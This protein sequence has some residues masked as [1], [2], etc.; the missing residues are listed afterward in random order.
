MAKFNPPRRQA[1]LGLSRALFSLANDV[2][3]SAIKTNSIKRNEDVFVSFPKR[4]F[5]D[6]GLGLDKR[7][8]LIMTVLT[9]IGKEGRRTL[10]EQ[11]WR[12]QVFPLEIITHGDDYW[13]VI[14]DFPITVPRNVGENYV[15][16]LVVHCNTKK[17]TMAYDVAT[18]KSRYR[19]VLARDH[20][21]ASNLTL[22]QLFDG[23]E[24][25]VRCG[26]HWLHY[27]PLKA[28]LGKL[29]Y[30][31]VSVLASLDIGSIRGLLERL[32]TKHSQYYVREGTEMIRYRKSFDDAPEWEMVHLTKSSVR[33][34]IAFEEYL[35]IR[36]VEWSQRQARRYRTY[37]EWEEYLAAKKGNLPHKIPS[38]EIP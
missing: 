24:T 15:R 5:Y 33:Y 29:G 8:K 6:G 38:R 32:S 4:V 1:T 26:S 20:P 27:D 25:Y 11:P 14:F 34:V 21:E 2:L 31:L 19:T 7:V 37:A 12:E 3:D 16:S 22:E 36:T 9:A 18:T 30:S 10:T 23:Y 13:S 17:Q 28:D 35:D